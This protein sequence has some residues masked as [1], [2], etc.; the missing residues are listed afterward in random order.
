MIVRCFRSSEAED[1]YDWHPVNHRAVGKIHMG[2]K[3]TMFL[4]A[5]NQILLSLVFLE[6]ALVYGLSPFLTILGIWGFVN[7]CALFSSNRIARITAL[8]WHLLFVAYVFI[9]SVGRTPTKADR[10]FIWWAVID[11]L[12]ISYLAKVSLNY[13]RNQRNP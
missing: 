11:L 2:N 12:V 1:I 5:I 9:S 6:V 4:I 10:P 3:L 8:A 13:L 7:G